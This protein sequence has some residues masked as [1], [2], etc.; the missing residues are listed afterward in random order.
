MT[1]A[2]NQLVLIPHW[3]TYLSTS[4]HK[5]WPKIND[6]KKLLMTSSDCLCVDGASDF[7]HDLDTTIIMCM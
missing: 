1:S 6:I 3:S 4:S 5:K 2:M 7:S